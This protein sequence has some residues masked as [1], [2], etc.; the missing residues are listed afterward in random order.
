MKKPISFIILV[1]LVQITIAQKL[2]YGNDLSAIKICNAIQGNNFLSESEADSAL[3]KIMQLNGIHFDWIVKEGIHENKGSDLGVIAQEV[4][5]IF[6]EI[7][8]TR[9][10]GYKAVKYD[11]LIAVL[12]QAVK[13]LNEKLDNK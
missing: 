12:I 5:A 1:L 13:E 6:P 8:E 11:R 2:D 3:D 10:N 4:E 9:Q 7:V